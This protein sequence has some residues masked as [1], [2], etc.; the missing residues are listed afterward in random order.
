MNT[1]PI[2][3]VTGDF[4]KTGGMDRANY[5]LADYLSKIGRTVDLVAYRAG[6]E[7]LA[8]PNVTLHQARKP[9]NS[10]T[11]GGPLLDRTGRRWAA[12]TTRQGGRVVVN[13]GNCVWGDVNWVHHVN[14]LDT[15]KPGGTLWRRFKTS[16]DYRIHI[17]AERLAL[18]RARFLMTTCEKNK[19]DIHKNFNKPLDRITTIYYGTDPAIFYPA[20]RDEKR[21]L[22]AKLGWPLD[23][24]IY[25]FVG[26]LSDRRKGF[27]TLF[28]AWAALCRRS[29]WDVDLVVVGTGAELDYWK[30]RAAAES[31]GDRIQFLG[32]RRDVSDL[33]RAS[34]AHVLPSRYEGYSLVTQEALCCGLPAF[35]TQSAGI[36][37]RY[38][39]GPLADGLLIP[40]PDDA[41]ALAERLASWRQHGEQWRQDLESFSG[42]LRSHTWD[43][44]AEQ[45]VSLLDRTHA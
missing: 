13:G 37:E 5:A 8:R 15:P 6:A 35:V 7:L 16:L 18:D 10:Y 22:R 33:F 23:R 17:R 31:L 41:P 32:F 1:A 29:D 26:G 44:M 11:L 2:L 20:D 45:I 24:P 21:S 3:L 19:V 25:T 30:S 38:P 42:A 14:L 40:D 12:R 34:D 36:A 43:N 27:D 28:D 9:L 39:A 4:V